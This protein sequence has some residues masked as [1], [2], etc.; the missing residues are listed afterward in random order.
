MQETIKGTDIKAIVIR[1][2]ALTTYVLEYYYRFGSG[3]QLTPL[4]IEMPITKHN[5]KLKE[6]DEITF[7]LTT[8]DTSIKS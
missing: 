7:Q 8:F 4:Q 2:N 3:P 1:K 6:G 5:H